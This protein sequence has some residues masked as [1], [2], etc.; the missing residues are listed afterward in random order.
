MINHMKR[1]T[2][3]LNSDQFTHLKKLAAIERRTL[4]SL[5]EDLIRLGLAARRRRSRGRRTTLPSWNMGT[6]KVDVAD[7][8]ALA[9]AM[10]GL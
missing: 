7:R 6:F 2:L 10:E 3:I 1:T 9:E 5:T 8:D 4:S